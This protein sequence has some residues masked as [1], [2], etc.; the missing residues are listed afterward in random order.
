MHGISATLSSLYSVDA[1]STAPAL[2]LHNTSQEKETADEKG[3]GVRGG[4]FC[5]F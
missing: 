3:G 1:P 2:R 5:A 4:T